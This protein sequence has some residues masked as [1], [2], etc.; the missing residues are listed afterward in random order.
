M[1]FIIDVELRYCTIKIVQDNILKEQDTAKNVQ[2][3][4]GSKM[5]VF[6]DILKMA[7]ERSLNKFKEETAENC[8]IKLND[9]LADGQQGM[10]VKALSTEPQRRIIESL[11]KVLFHQYS[12]SPKE[13]NI[14]D[15]HVNLLLPLFVQKITVECVSED[16]V[17]QIASD[18][19]KPLHDEILDILTKKEPNNKTYNKNQNRTYGIHLFYYS[20]LEMEKRSAFGLSEDF[21]KID[22]DDDEDTL[23]SIDQEISAINIPFSNTTFGKT[24]ISFLPSVNFDSLW[25][26]L[27]FKDDIKQRMFNYSTISL[28]VAKLSNQEA[29]HG[30]ED[31]QLMT[32]K[33]LLI[34]GP[35]G[36]GKTTL[37]R[38][39]CQKLAIRNGSDLD[40]MDLV[41]KCILVEI[42]SSSIF[43]RWFGES[44]KNIT[45]LFDDIEKLVRE[46]EKKDIFVCVLID[47]VEAIASSRTDILSKSE[48]T[49][50]VRVVNAL[51]THLDKLKYYNNFLL[52]ATS[53]L[54]DNIDSAFLDRAD[55]IFHIGNPVE[56]AITKILWTSIGELISA[57]I[58]IG[59]KSY[60]YILNSEIYKDIICTIAKNANGRTLRKIPLLCLSEHF[61][62]LPIHLDAFLV[63]LAH[64]VVALDKNESDK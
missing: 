10:E 11:F 47:E 52:L 14:E 17:Q 56:E 13:F 25:E 2:A 42:S 45:T 40:N 20:P 64:T 51:L 29:Q 16:L 33:L 50:G 27:Y 6:S 53:N 46:A 54:L 44:A 62:D 3:K 1:H 32:N 30:Y 41:Y 60:R 5:Q 22:L 34:H 21:D 12:N 23:R 7:I 37:C 59:Y 9:L 35:P 24:R 43:S 26:S 57:G 15:G 48:S 38:A 55:G 36:T 19:K 18:D 39:L 58:I 49:D 8:A 61:R 63:G 28:K 31:E 4:E